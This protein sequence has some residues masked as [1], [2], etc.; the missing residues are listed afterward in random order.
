MTKRQLIDE[1]LT[2]NH[3]ARPSFLAKFE[4]ADLSEYLQHLQAV[5][6]P[7]RRAWRR[8]Q[9]GHFNKPVSLSPAHAQD[10]TQYASDQ[11]VPPGGNPLGHPVDQAVL[12]VASAPDDDHP[13]IPDGRTGQKWLF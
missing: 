11:P 8:T 6:Q 9:T 13:A 4:D 3:S 5:R 12:A 1:I 7:R 10:T 2:L